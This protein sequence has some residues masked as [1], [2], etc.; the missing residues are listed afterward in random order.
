[1][2]NLDA[3]GSEN[4]FFQELTAILAIMKGYQLLYISN[5]FIALIPSSSQ[6]FIF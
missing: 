3:G 6:I 2:F 5:S 1:M 4:S